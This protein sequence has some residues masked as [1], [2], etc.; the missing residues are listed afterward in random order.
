LGAGLC[1][2]YRGR[3][4]HKLDPEAGNVMEAFSPADVA[5]NGTSKDCQSRCAAEPKCV[6]FVTYL[7]AALDGAGGA[8]SLVMEAEGYPAI[9][10]GNSSFE[11]FWRHKFKHNS[12][13]IY[14]SSQPNVPKRM[15]SY[16]ENMPQ[17]ASEAAVLARNTAFLEIC[18]TSWRKLN[19]GWEIRILDQDSMW[20]YISRSEL[21]EAFEQLSIQHRSD[22]IRLALLVKYGGVWLDASVLLL[23][24]WL[25]MAADRGLRT[26]YVN[27][28]LDGFPVI[29]QTKF[30][31]ARYN[32]NFHVENWFYEAPP[33]DPLL[34]RTFN[35][36]KQM[37]RNSDHR[38]LK[39]YAELFSVRQLED[40][41]AL[42]IWAYLATDA[43]MWKVLDEDKALRDWW[44]SPSVQR[45]N[46]LGH[47]N[48]TWFANYSRAYT[49]LF[50]QVTPEMVNFLTG[51]EV[52]L[53]KLTHDMRWALIDP[54]T[55]SELW[56]CTQS[57]WALM[58]TDIG[59]YDAQKCV[60]LNSDGT[61]DTW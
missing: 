7:G 58:L 21:P 10:D 49:Q 48:P 5:I 51:G 61:P 8:C 25:S 37:H 13:G 9:G 23:Q 12:V 36:V 38:E 15:W 45:I 40:L 53:L 26:F 42:G 31:Y 60:S 52:N 35:C 56:G 39:D 34:A 20:Q 1:K 17:D 54:A 16:W 3:P 55:P 44:L 30:S 32:A 43:C 4:L 19:P 14:A 50:R 18:H 6:G 11:C 57:S 29:N 24:P 22:A 47:M 41:D 46:F 27:L 28:G 59:V 2:D 33:Q